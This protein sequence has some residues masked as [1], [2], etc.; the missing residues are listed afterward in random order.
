MQR[1]FRFLLP[2]FPILLLCACSR[3]ETNI[4]VTDVFHQT[5]TQQIQV[6]YTKTKENVSC[7]LGGHGCTINTLEQDLY[8]IT[9]PLE[10][11]SLTES[12]LLSKSYLIRSDTNQNDYFYFRS[13]QSIVLGNT[14]S[15]I[16]ELCYPN[17]DNGC[18]FHEQIEIDE[19]TRSPLV[20]SDTGQNFFWHNTLYT[21]ASL[22]PSD[23]NEKQGYQEFVNG[24]GTLRE[25]DS[26]SSSVKTYLFDDQTLLAKATFASAADSPLGLVYLVTEDTTAWILKNFESG[27][28]SI[29]VLGVQ[30]HQNEFYF[31]L[32]LFDFEDGTFNRLLNTYYLYST[33]DGSLR[34][35]ED[36]EYR[37]REHIWDTA[38]QTLYKVSTS[39]NN[40]IRITED[41]LF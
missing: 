34:E 35:I 13:N 8:Q 31:L 21:V 3:T 14:Q 10:A 12:E 24:I 9:M 30:K 19:S 38:T 27:E 36:P 23:L 41:R 2:I 15:Q 16:L 26:T 20:L 17:E 33:A 32:N 18:S 40:G 4:K 6:L 5:E 22:E 25:N 29:N 28:A 11:G 7:P 1:L 37:E 39:A